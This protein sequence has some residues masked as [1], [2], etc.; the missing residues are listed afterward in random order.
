MSLLE[1]IGRTLGSPLATG[2]SVSQPARNSEV[3][4]ALASPISRDLA[5]PGDVQF[6][7]GDAFLFEQIFANLTPAAALNITDLAVLLVDNSGNTLIPALGTPILTTI[8]GIT[9]TVSVLFPPVPLLTME[10]L[11]NFGRT[12]GGD[13][14]NAQP[15]R[16]R[17]RVAFSASTIVLRWGFKARIFH[18]LQEG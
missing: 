15:P 17:F 10:D 4:A 9:Q 5:I 16:V 14:L 3:T 11:I 8:T 6:G 7:R 2:S 13:P 18:G 12:F 1:E